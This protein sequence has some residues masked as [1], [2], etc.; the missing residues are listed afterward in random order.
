MQLICLRRRGLRIWRKPRAVGEKGK[1]PTSI[2]KK[3]RKRL[4]FSAKEI[5]GLRAELGSD[6]RTSKM[7]GMAQS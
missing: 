1:L 6:W 7:Q 5:G 2:P 4:L 3:G